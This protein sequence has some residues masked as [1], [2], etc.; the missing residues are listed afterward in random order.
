MTEPHHPRCAIKQQHG[1]RYRELKI[2]QGIKLFRRE[3]PEKGTG[4]NT[5]LLQALQRHFIRTGNKV[6][7]AHPLRKNIHHTYIKRIPENT[8]HI[9]FAGCVGKRLHLLRI[10]FCIKGGKIPAAP[11]VIKAGLHQHIVWP[12]QP[13]HSIPVGRRQFMACRMP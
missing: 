6:K 10:A 11:A 1:R 9:G 5:Q 3:R 8:G 2:C 12:H 7:S 13:Y 4:G